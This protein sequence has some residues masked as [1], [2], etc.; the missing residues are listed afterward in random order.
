M[1]D[2]ERSKIGTAEFER[3]TRKTFDFPSDILYIELVYPGGVSCL[4]TQPI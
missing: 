1:F 4:S 2:P 3:K